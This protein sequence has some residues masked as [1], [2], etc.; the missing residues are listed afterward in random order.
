MATAVPGPPYVRPTPA[1]T[2]GRLPAC[3]RRPSG[4]IMRWTPPCGAPGTDV[5]GSPWKGQ[6]GPY[7]RAYRRWRG[8][9]KVG[10]RSRR[11]QAAGVQWLEAPAGEDLQAWRLLPPHAPDPRRKVRPLPRQE[12]KGAR[13]P[14]D[15]GSRP[16]AAGQAQQGG[17][18]ACQQA[19]PHRLGGVEARARLRVTTAGRLTRDRNDSPRHCTS[20]EPDGAHSIMARSPRGTT[21]EA[22]DTFAVPTLSLSRAPPPRG[23]DS[24][25]GLQGTEVR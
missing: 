9:R 3:H 25:S 12:G 10:L 14:Q 6:G 13:P 21:Q 11:V 24:P 17:G 7:G 5:P 4:A 2:C 20:E 16:G 23:A 18:G 19:G 1:F 8:H 22:E 15:L